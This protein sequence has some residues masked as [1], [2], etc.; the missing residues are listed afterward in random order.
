MLNVI[1]ISDKSQPLLNKYLTGQFPTVPSY[2]DAQLPPLYAQ[3]Y[4]F[5]NPYPYVYPTNTNY[6]P[7]IFGSYYNL[8][9]LKNNQAYNLANALPGSPY[10]P[11]LNPN[12]L[13]SSAAKPP[14]TDNGNYFFP[15]PP[16]GYEGK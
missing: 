6:A 1:H 2:Y 10:P 16:R 14:L 4:K 11:S 5:P 3:S 7:P 15:Y 9:H 8:P 13:P 12:N